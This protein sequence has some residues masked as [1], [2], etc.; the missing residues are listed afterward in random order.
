MKF[1]IGDIV[2]Y[3]DIVTVVINDFKDDYYHFRILTN[4]GDWP[5]QI[6]KFRNISM[7]YTDSTVFCSKPICKL[8]V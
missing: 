5:P 6:T 1:Q 8:I 4:S 2:N 7:F 3:R